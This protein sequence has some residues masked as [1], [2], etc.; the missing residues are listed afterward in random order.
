MSDTIFYKGVLKRGKD[1][2]AVFEKITK[3]I[4]KR[5]PSKNWTYTIDEEQSSLLID[6][7]DDKSETFFLQ[8][9]EKG[10][11]DDCCK[12]AFPLEG[13]LFEDGKSEFKAL[14]DALY[15]AR[16]SFRSIE[17]TDDFGLAECYWDSK[18]FKFHFRDLTAEE[19][20]RVRRLY[21]QGS[22]TPEQLL[23]SIMAEDMEM[24][25]EEL[26]DYVNINTNY[27]Q[28]WLSPVHLTLDAYLYETAEFRNEGRL[29]EIP[30][31]NYY[32]LGNV[33][34]SEFAFIE[35]LSW[36]F[37]DGTGQDTAISLE[38]K[39]AFSQKDAQVG[40]L[41]REKFAPVFIA[42]TDP[43]EK[44]ILAY[45]YFV[46]IYGGLGFRFVGRTK[47][48]KMVMEKI[49]EEY[50]EEKGT[51]YLTCYCTT[52]RYVF[53]NYNPE[54]KKQYSDCLIKNMTERYGED[55][56]SEYLAFKRKYENDSKFRRETEYVADRKLKYIDDSLVL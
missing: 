47:N 53:H 1:P 2:L 54:T 28:E 22:T 25:V 40:L 27:T 46:S 41:F 14:L 30:D 56:F 29:C 19:D 18:R 12:V 39:R 52:E 13:E 34:F 32:N 55:F 20:E 31:W 42:E 48:R 26:R 44:C 38:K 35:G 24:P 45:R 9:K 50:G 15:K 51:I 4:G 10:E 23:R 11:F 37:L 3:G 16:T 8:F 5:G 21:A 33:Y 36:V 17:V 7:Q 49:L 43:L 6:F